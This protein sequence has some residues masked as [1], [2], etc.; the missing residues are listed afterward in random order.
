MPS[1]VCEMLSAPVSV[2][3]KIDVFKVGPGIKHTNN[4][5]SHSR[6]FPA[7]EYPED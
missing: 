1:A 5:I 6:Y 4:M 7:K 2:C 3:L